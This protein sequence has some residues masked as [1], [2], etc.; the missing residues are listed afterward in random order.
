MSQ[1]VLHPTDKRLSP[2]RSM[3]LP[4]MFRIRARMVTIAEAIDLNCAIPVI[5]MSLQRR[6]RSHEAEPF[7][8]KLLVAL[9][10]QFDPHAMTHAADAHERTTA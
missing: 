10:H 3:A 7:G 6:F 2:C 5:T 9:R 8:D 1:S 4:P